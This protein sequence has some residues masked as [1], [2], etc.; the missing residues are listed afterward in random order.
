MSSSKFVKQSYLRKLLWQSEDCR[1]CLF[2]IRTLI[3]LIDDN[4]CTVF[5]VITLL[6]ALNPLGDG[7]WGRLKF[8]TEEGMISVPIIMM[9][10]PVWLRIDVLSP[11]LKMLKH[12]PTWCCHF[13]IILE[14]ASPCWGYWSS[15]SP[16]IF[17][18]LSNSAVGV[19]WDVSFP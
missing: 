11:N 5:L 6:P 19:E 16:A 8:M 12:N 3:R 2:D 10:L 17:L 1:F 7:R 14:V 9:P 18:W 13:W 15:P 4:F